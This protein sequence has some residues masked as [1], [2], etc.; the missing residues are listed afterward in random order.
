MKILAS[1]YDDKYSSKYSSRNYDDVTFKVLVRKLR[2]EFPDEF[3]NIA[4]NIDSMSLEDLKDV[5][6]ECVN[7]Y[8]DGDYSDAYISED[9]QSLIDD[10]VG[11]V[12]DA[13]N[14]EDYS[15]ELWGE[16]FRDACRNRMYDIIH[17]NGYDI[18]DPNIIQYVIDAFEGYGEGD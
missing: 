8:D 2:R 4:R 18:D 3:R 15:K 11:N 10:N 9:V 16:D 7:N 14:D 17:D 13:I 5:Y 1:K 6:Y 12:V